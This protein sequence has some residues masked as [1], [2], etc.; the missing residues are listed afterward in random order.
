LQQDA[1]AC[2]EVITNYGKL[3]LQFSRN[4]EYCQYSG[5]KKNNNNNNNNNNNVKIYEVKV[6]GGWKLQAVTGFKNCNH[7]PKLV[8]GLEGGGGE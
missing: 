1:L 8:G 6:R 2:D 5:L 4:L 7:R 3:Q